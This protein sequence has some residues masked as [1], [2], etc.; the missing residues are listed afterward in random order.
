MAKLV[1]VYTDAYRDFE[2]TDMSYI[3]WLKISEALARRG[4]QVDIATNE[5]ILHQKN[6]PFP[7]GQN[8]RRIL[9]P[10]VRWSD[11]DVVKTLFH[12]GF[13]TLE[14]YGGKDHPFI[15]SKLGSVVGPID[16]N[17]IYFY[18]KK[19]EQ[20]F[21]TQ[22]K[23]N[24]TSKYVTV[25]NASAKELWTNSLG[26]RDNILLV[27]GGV[28]PYIPPRSKNP[29]PKEKHTR[30]IFAGHV[31]TKH[32]QPEANTVIINKLNK[33]GK[34]LSDLG[35]RLYMVGSGDVRKLDERFVT[36]LGV[37]PYEEAW[38][39]FHFAHVGIVVAAGQ[40]MHNNESSK[41]YH[42]LRVG[43]PVVSEAG[44]PNDNVVIESRLGFVVQN[45]NL[46]LMAQK[47]EEA[48]HKDWDRDY[49][50]N[51]I[52]ENHTWDKRVETYDRIMKEKFNS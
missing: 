17:G 14:T 1:T 27:P 25:L 29:Y 21:L 9:L 26:P 6:S 50:I 15:I 5:S 33:L 19:R 10:K 46:E 18:G 31:Y 3:R 24:Q 38:N 48:A 28:D 13:D 35:V 2:P 41:I 43:L 40:F 16:M 4:H 51:Y 44:F 36:Y 39:Y 37:A 49:A 30:C 8:L 34:L 42:Y 12:I 20:F 11:Y 23:I 47:I 22:K 45:G 32:S 52:L 7:M